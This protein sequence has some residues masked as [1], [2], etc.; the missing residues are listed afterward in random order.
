MPISISEKVKKSKILLYT[1]A[2]RPTIKPIK[3]AKSILR[4]LLSYFIKAD[5]KT[6]TSTAVNI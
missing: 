1:K 2:I 5:K 3:N 4:Y 6:T